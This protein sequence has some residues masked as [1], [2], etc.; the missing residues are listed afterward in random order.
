MKNQVRDKCLILLTR[1]KVKNCARKQ[2]LTFDLLPH[3]T[4]KLIFTS[5]I[6]LRIVDDGF[7][8]ATINMFLIT[9]LRNSTAPRDHN[10]AL[11]EE[12]TSITLVCNN[13]VSYLLCLS[14]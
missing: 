8:T 2:R 5:L 12:T 6:H 4:F 9:T 1:K 7:I 10:G 11:E 3:F 13:I 14:K